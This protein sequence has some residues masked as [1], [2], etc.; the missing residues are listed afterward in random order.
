MIFSR[1]LDRRARDEASSTQ[2]IVHSSE[3]RG[4]LV[5]SKTVGSQAGESAVSER[6]KPEDATDL[7]STFPRVSPR[8]THGSGPRH[9]RSH[10][11]TNP[12]VPGS[13]ITI[14]EFPTPFLSTSAPLARDARV[15]AALLASLPTWTT[16]RPW[17]RGFHRNGKEGKRVAK[18]RYR[19]PDNAGE[20]EGP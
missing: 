2:N 3:C 16:D 13:P 15:K 10:D 11:V 6:P 8:R 14:Q 17:G 18:K 9:L 19:R 12:S 7:W 4:D 5:F 1:K 20:S